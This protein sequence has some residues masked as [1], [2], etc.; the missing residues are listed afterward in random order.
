MPEHFALYV[1]TFNTTPNDYH[2]NKK[3]HTFCI[4]A[5]PRE[6]CNFKKFMTA[7]KLLKL[8]SK[9]E[10]PRRSSSICLEIV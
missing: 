9:P 7:R 3:I 10:Q 6:Y 2:R 4:I 8:P 1:K 5:C